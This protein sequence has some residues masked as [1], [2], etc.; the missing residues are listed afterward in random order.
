MKKF[1]LDILRQL[2]GLAKPRD[3]KVILTR[4]GFARMTEYEIDESTI[5]DVFRNGQEKKPGMVIQ[6]DYEYSVGIDYKYDPAE[7]QYV[8]TTCWKASR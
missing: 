1:M 2:F 3:G 5:R 8:I 6:Y 7:H 4:H